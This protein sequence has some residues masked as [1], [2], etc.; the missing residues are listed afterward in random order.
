MSIDWYNAPLVDMMC[1]IRHSSPGDTLVFCDSVDALVKNKIESSAQD[2]LNIPSYWF[3]ENLNFLPLTKKAI[4]K[5]L[6]NNFDL[7]KTKETSYQQHMAMFFNDETKDLLLGHHI[8]NN[9]IHI[10]IVKSLISPESKYLTKIFDY[11]I[12]R[13]KRGDR[14]IREYIKFIFTVAPAD[15]EVF[16]NMCERLS[17]LT[18]NIKSILLTRNDIKEEYVLCGLKALAKLKGHKSIDA[19]I[20]LDLLKK[21]GPKS[22]L[23]AFEQIIGYK[24]NRYWYC[25][26]DTK[27]LINPIPTKEEVA[28]L[29][30][31]C[32]IINFE[33][34]NGVIKFY[35]NLLAQKNKEEQNV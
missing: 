33:R 9:Y 20:S 22:R 6:N 24:Q 17:K 23:N 10:G 15:G 12:D 29:L 16:D 19:S 25:S 1:E 7:I 28:E 8:N 13:Y 31:P 21:L 30:F 4:E 34:V 5:M 2:L 11:F 26:Y 27:M 32:L 14:Y 3:S 18:P 35:E